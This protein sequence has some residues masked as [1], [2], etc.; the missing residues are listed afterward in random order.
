MSRSEILSW[1]SLA[2]SASVIVFYILIVFGWPDAI[3]DY[4]ARFTKIFFNVFWVAVV[5]EIIVGISEE[6]R[7]IQ[8][9]ERDI[10]I[11]GKGYK[12]GYIFLVIA[13]AFALVQ[14]F[15]SGVIGPQGEAYVYGLPFT[16]KDI[17]H[18]LFLALFVA[19]AAKRTTMIY[20][21]RRES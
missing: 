3:P 15:L 13:T 14:F 12:V 8:K 1:T 5:I 7:K 9:D 6:K 10:K 4:S 21:Y 19:S 2:T 20:H 16:P 18:L 11:E 17:F